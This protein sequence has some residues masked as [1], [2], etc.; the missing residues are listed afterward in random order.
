MGLFPACPRRIDRYVYICK[1]KS[2]LIYKIYFISFNNLIA[3]F[4]YENA[5]NVTN[6]LFNNNYS[7][8]IISVGGHWGAAK[9]PQNVQIVTENILEYSTYS[10][11]SYY[12]Y[13][14]W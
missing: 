6:N 13:Y 1:Y 4:C 7:N 11:M 14:V 12:E 5:L 8:C 3:F 10:C 2:N 9:F